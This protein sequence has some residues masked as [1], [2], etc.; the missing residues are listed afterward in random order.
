M[1]RRL[2]AA[3]EWWLAYLSAGPAGTI[4]GGEHVVA[5][6]EW[7]LYTDAEGWGGVGAVLVHVASGACQHIV[8]SV[9]RRVQRAL[10][11]RRT[12]INVFELLAVLMALESY[13]P[14]LSG[15]RVVCFVDNKAALGM[16][17]KGWSRADDANAI[18]A[19][20]WWTMAAL[21]IEI[22]WEYVPS[23]LNLADGPSRSKVEEVLSLGSEV[24]EANWSL[25]KMTCEEFT[26][27]RDVAR[28]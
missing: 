9:P 24:V 12:Q 18:A 19:Q 1:S 7:V 17:V 23:K 26:S 20:C 6:P 21:G 4:R 25:C 13:G 11:P 3:L 2:V 14:V 16:L 8:S 5:A 27:Q 22:F 28:I 15:C 10:L